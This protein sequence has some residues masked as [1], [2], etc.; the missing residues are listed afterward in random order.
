[1]GV[2]LW[3]LGRRSQQDRARPPRPRQG[4]PTQAETLTYVERKATKIVEALTTCPSASACCCTEKLVRKREWLRKFSNRSSKLPNIRQGIHNSRRRQP[5]AV[6]MY[7]KLDSVNGE[8][9]DD[10]HA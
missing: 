5:M 6:D 3:L 2:P 9:I 7:L 1:M 10:S 8:S 4:Q